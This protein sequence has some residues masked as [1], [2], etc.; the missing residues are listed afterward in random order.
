MKRIMKRA[1]VML[2]TASIALSSVPVQDV[3]AEEE[4][5]TETILEESTSQPVAEEAEVEAP[6]PAAEAAEVEVPQPVAEEVAD[7]EETSVEAPECATTGVFL[8]GSDHFNDPESGITAV[9]RETGSLAANVV[10][11]ADEEFV[12]W[13]VY[14][15]DP[16]GEIETLGWDH[17]IYG[18]SE[19]ELIFTNLPNLY[20]YGCYEIVAKGIDA[21]GE[22]IFY[23]TQFK[24]A[25]LMIHIS[26]V[27]IFDDS[28]KTVEIQGDFIPDG[29]SY[30][31]EVGSFDEND[32]FVK[33]IT[34]ETNEDNTC[35]LTKELLTS[36]WGNDPENEAR[37]CLRVTVVKGD[38]EIASST[39]DVTYYQD[40]IEFPSP[41]VEMLR[42]DH[43][44][45][46]A[47][48][49]MWVRNSKYPDGEYVNIRVTSIESDTVQ[50]LFD[51]EVESYNFDYSNVT[52]DSGSMLFK[53][54]IYDSEGNLS[55][56]EYSC[57]GTYII[58]DVMYGLNVKVKGADP[59]MVKGQK[60]T[61]IL[62]LHKRWVELNDGEYWFFGE[63]I[64]LGD[65]VTAEWIYDESE[66][67]KYVKIQENKD[68]S[69]EVEAIEAVTD[70]AQVPLELCVKAGDEIVTERFYL[71]LLTEAYRE[72]II[73]DVETGK[74]FEDEDNLKI[75][76]SKTIR[77]AV[78]LFTN[79]N[80]S[81][82]EL[83]A[84][85]HMYTWGDE[86][87][88]EIVDNNDGTY[89]ITRVGE[90]TRAFGFEGIMEDGTTESSIYLDSLWTDI[91]FYADGNEEGSIFLFTDSKTKVTAVTD[92]VASNVVWDWD[93][94]VYDQSD[95][96]EVACID[97]AE[98]TN[99][100][101]I[102][103]DGSSYTQYLADQ[104]DYDFYIKL[105][106]YVGEKLVKTSDKHLHYNEARI[107]FYGMP[108]E[109]VWLK[110]SQWEIPIYQRMYIENS[111]HPW[112]EK[113]DIKI[114]SVTSDTM[115]IPANAEFYELDYKNATAD[116]G[117]ITLTYKV[118]DWE[119]ELS[120][121]EFTYTAAYEYKDSLY[122]LNVMTKGTQG[123]MVK[124]QKKTLIPSLYKQWME[125]DDGDY[126]HEDAEIQIAGS[127][128]AEWIYDET[129]AGKYLDIQE[130]SDGSLTVEVIRGVEDEREVRIPVQF[131]VK[132]G[133]EVLATFD[134]E[135]ALTS[136]YDQI[137]FF[138]METGKEF[139]QEENLKLGDSVTIR[140]AVMRFS[141]DNPSG[142]DQNIILHL[143]ETSGMDS[144]EMTDNGDGTYTIRR[145]KED[146]VELYCYG[147][148]SDSN[149]DRHFS[150]PGWWSDIRYSVDGREGNELILYKDE[151]IQIT[152]SADAISENLVWDWDL[153]IRDMESWDVIGRVDLARDENLRAVTLDGSE[154]A[155]YSSDR[156]EL[157]LEVNLYAGDTLVKDH[158]E[159]VSYREPWVETQGEGMCE[160]L[161]SRGIGFQKNYEGWVMTKDYPDGF[162]AELEIRNLKILTGKD[163][164]REDYDSENGFY[165]FNVLKEGLAVL[166]YDVYYNDKLMREDVIFEIRGVIRNYCG[167]VV[168]D[169]DRTTIFKNESITF[170]PDY[171]VDGYS[172]AGHFYKE[173]ID[174]L[175]IAVANVFYDCD[176]ECG[177][178]ENYVTISENRNG[179][180]TYEPNGHDCSVE[181]EMD[182]YAGTVKIDSVV[183]YVH[184][185][186]RETRMVI[187][188]EKELLALKSGES[189]TVKPM[190]IRVTEENPEGI[191]LDTSTLNLMWWHSEGCFEVTDHEDGT[192]TITRLSPR[193]EYLE[194]AYLMGT[195][196]DDIL[197][198]WVG[199]Y[200]CEHKN[201]VWIDGKDA[202]CL[203]IGYRE[204]KVCEDCGYRVKVRGK[205]NKL[206]HEMTYYEAKEATCTEGGTVEYWS[207]SVC[208]KN[209][210]SEKAAKEL[211]TVDVDKLGH[212]MSF[213]EKVYPTYETDGTKE[214]YKCEREICGKLYWDE[215]ATSEITKAEDVVIPKLAYTAPEVEKD[216]S[217]KADV[218]LNNILKLIEEDNFENIPGVS[219]ETAEKIKETVDSGY[220]IMIETVTES[221]EEGALA[222]FITKIEEEVPYE[223]GELE[224]KQLLDISMMI[225]K[226][227]GENSETLG[228]ITE[229]E[230]PV[231]L[232]FADVEAAP[233][234]M[235]YVVIRLHKNADKTITVD[236][237]EAKQDGTKVSFETD[238]FSVYALALVPDESTDWV[239][240]F[241]GGEFSL[242]L[243][244]ELYVEYMPDLSNFNP[245]V[246]AEGKGGLAIWKG[247]GRP[248]SSR[249]VMP[250]AQN[251]D[252][253][254]NMHW[255]DTLHKWTFTTMGIPAR[256][257][258]D[259][260]YMRPFIELADG[261]YVTGG[262]L[263]YSPEEFCKKKLNSDD[264]PVK[265]KALCASILEY[266]AAAQ[267]YFDY[268]DKDDTVNG[269]D[270]VNYENGVKLNYSDYFENADSLLAYS[271][272]LLDELVPLPSGFGAQFESGSIKIPSAKDHAKATLTLEG[273]VVIDIINYDVP[274]AD[275]DHALLQVWSEE[276]LLATKDFTYDSDSCTIKVEMGYGTLVDEEGYVATM[277][278]ENSKYVGVPAKECG[279]TVYFM[280]YFV[281]KDGTIYRNG[282]RKY[283]PD[284]YVRSKVEGSNPTDNEDLKDLCKGLAVYSEK[285]R[286]YF[287]YKPRNNG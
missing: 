122:W 183:E 60:K 6:Q 263:V 178:C 285:A 123:W 24:A 227:S 251:C 226:I 156:T 197:N 221:I 146:Y 26:P 275:I 82:T 218:I 254:K 104:K 172:T 224:F 116:S 249:L 128:T 27:E 216:F 258:G 31:W 181:L 272:E 83:E 117:T 173:E 65:E 167:Q 283:S 223:A 70:F 205:I 219:A 210:P 162:Y 94:V 102:T 195:S 135:I 269:E 234:G 171:Y 78:M 28:K 32:E 72:L 43:W 93:L 92:N 164:V 40:M 109:L 141:N 19:K 88:V 8:S 21:N 81:G 192:Y 182:V 191:E 80:P 154:I 259:T 132:D 201:F 139:D 20:A 236:I 208:E 149:I 239:G 39:T 91:E 206:S 63:R 244:G 252:T 220:E 74:K 84:E 270:L 98:G 174:D 279:D 75:G 108:S 124:G 213:V 175:R 16:E 266:G 250:D 232:S 133:E 38:C 46:C 56:E 153:V 225:K 209:Y 267:N 10:M 45:Y 87:S 212:L 101:T 188:N 207:C 67:D 217:E 176:E 165:N 284:E 129:V 233:S 147:E 231:T 54:K 274:V 36:V 200:E 144:S 246:L 35:T 58:K 131:I 189:V 235:K 29:L 264:T 138:D 186:S 204:A 202:T 57:T 103:L 198:L 59:W 142:A 89:T 30:R 262:I 229:L 106:L 168:T 238:K 190:R 115:V 237:L 194:C 18:A 33:E 110:H 4:H 271:A 85:H 111:E 163:V 261:T 159:Y 90:D 113:L 166:S 97:I 222:E 179:T 52:A 105:Q 127:I 66:A 25:E 214:H 145:V 196:S 260:L 160:I 143:E 76:E 55:E 112:G 169:L 150:L 286:T 3:Y 68:G 140:P 5:V 13:E 248:S 253:L 193:N 247:N 73:Y 241:A 268:K 22:S 277:K 79:D 282:M 121:E 9:I 14:H 187:E 37:T 243:E 41:D 257:Y 62:E 256:Q 120:E 134:E 215:D 49:E 151:I 64:N 203:E 281:A 185:I 184:I 50:F 240:E 15:I 276:D 155:K 71:I 177:E 17:Y 96:D 23:S 130:N 180:V 136:L 7:D 118:Y 170:T 48:Q 95:W 126:W 53:Y 2:L 47:E 77:P 1:F 119:G 157:C 61:Y 34:L 114:T 265:L 44:G 287:N 199:H 99:L 11:G 245:K 148:I 280:T 228:E 42:G 161:V 230:N 242:S 12:E 86:E 125:E 158:W 51:E 69:L 107:E 278:D 273:A 211:T 100:R 137:I 152:A 255:S